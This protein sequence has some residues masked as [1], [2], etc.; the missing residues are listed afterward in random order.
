MLIIL[1]YI[2]VFDAFALGKVGNPLFAALRYNLRLR[3][4][5]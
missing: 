1:K 4:S 3:L 2:G 5:K